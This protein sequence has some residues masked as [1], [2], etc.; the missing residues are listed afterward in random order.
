MN[1]LLTRI[2]DAHGGIIVSES[3]KSVE[4]AIVSG[5]SFFPLKEPYRM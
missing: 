2:L 3:I 4:A 1:E 5:A